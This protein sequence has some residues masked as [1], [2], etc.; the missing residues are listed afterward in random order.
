[1]E[2]KQTN[3]ASINP[4]VPYV[5]LRTCSDLAVKILERYL[6]MAKSGEIIGVSLAAVHLDHTTTFAY[7]GRMGRSMTGALMEMIMDMAK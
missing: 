6:E 2:E 1:M 3:V 4:N 7:R 5:D